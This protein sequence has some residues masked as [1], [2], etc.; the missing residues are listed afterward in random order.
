VKLTAAVTKLTAAID[1]IKVSAQSVG[2]A[3]S[4]ATRLGTVLDAGVSHV[5][6]LAEV[7]FFLNRLAAFETVF[8]SSNSTALEEALLDFFKNKT[9][10]FA[11][12]EALASDFYKALT[13]ATGFTDAQ[14]FEFFKAL[15][16]NPTYIDAFVY[17]LERGIADDSAAADSYVSNVDKPTSDNAAVSEISTASVFKNTAEIVPTTDIYALFYSKFIQSSISVTDDVDG[18]ASILDDQ[19][20]LFFKAITQPAT[21]SDVFYR[22]VAY[23]RAFSD[24]TAIADVVATAFS[25][26]RADAAAVSQQHYFDILRGIADTSGIAEQAAK[27]FSPAPFLDAV[28]IADSSF[29]TSGLGKSE[30]T[31]F[32]DTG[33]LRSQGYCDFTYFA[34]DYVGASRTF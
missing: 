29:S 25:T 26:S 17:K 11:V 32:S 3:Q 30:S 7:G 1:R 13:D 19:E 6:L 23:V 15:E 24:A 14:V 20:M 31:L 28:S 16:E 4:A 22:L 18:A 8:A 2:G 27:A 5:Q 21:L 9:D 34:E 12:A 10:D 33:S